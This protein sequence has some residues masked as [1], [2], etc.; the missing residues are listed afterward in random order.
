MISKRLAV[1]ALAASVTMAAGAAGAQS[2]DQIRIVGSSTVFPFSTMVAETFGRGGK[3]KT[4]VVESTG[5]GG[6]FKAFCAGIGPQYPDISNASRPITTSEKEGCA[7]AG[8]TNIAE[9]TIGYDG[10]T[11]AVN[12]KSKAFPVTVKQLWLALAAEVPVGGKLVMNPNTK[13][14]EIDPA[15]PNTAIEVYGPAKVH[16]TRDAFNELVM[17][18]GCK[19]LPE[20][21]ALAADV[22]KKTCQ[23]MREDGAW[24][25]V[26]ED[27]ALIV[28]K[29]K[30]NPEAVGVFTF[31]YI[32]QNADKVTGLNVNGVKP[33]FDNILSKKYP[34][35]RPLFFYVKSAHVGTIPGLPDYVTE[36]LSTKAVGTDGYLVNKGLI[37]LPPAE[38]TQQQAAAAALAK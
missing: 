15:L 12:A 34:L 6:G 20:I 1:A 37:P 21:A 22:K 8:V 17:D 5:T 25:D 35:S 27:Y 18:Q 14:S 29:L 26:S 33:T 36:F 9:F 13:W 3:F 28:G 32:D 16:G 7:K 31:F 10:V 38:L 23:A 2:R 11:V 4:P 24:V 19:E 30:S